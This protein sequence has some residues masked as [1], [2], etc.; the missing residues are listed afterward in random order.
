MHWKIDTCVMAVCT[1]SWVVKLTD[2]TAKLQSQ[3][4]GI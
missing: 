4:Q 2:W 1:L 3:L